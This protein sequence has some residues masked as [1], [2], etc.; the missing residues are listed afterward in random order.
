MCDL[1]DLIIF[2]LNV[3]KF[4]ILNQKEE[5]QCDSTSVCVPAHFLTLLPST[6]YI[7]FLETAWYYVIYSFISC[8]VPYLTLCPSRAG[9]FYLWSLI[10][11]FD[12]YF[13]TPH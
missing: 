9:V 5:T 3:T 2:L 11:A 6:Y 10:E 8:L 13:L 12:R 4:D 7:V 1:S